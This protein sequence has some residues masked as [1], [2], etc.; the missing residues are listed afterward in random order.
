[1]TALP[2]ISVI[3]PAYNGKEHL[4]EAVESVLSQDYPN[5]ELLI[6][7]D[8]ST[9]GCCDS[10]PQSPILKLIRKSNGGVAEARNWGV[11]AS[12]GEFLAFLDQDDVWL[13]T[14]LSRQW[15]QL[16][17][18]EGEGI[19]LVFHK[20]FWKEGELP[21]K[22]AKTELL[23]S[24]HTS[25]VPGSW[26]FSRSLMEKVGPFDPV[27]RFGSDYDWL[28]RAKHQ[29]VPLLT[30]EEPLLLKRLHEGNESQYVK[31]VHK[32]LALLLHRSI[33]RHKQAPTSSV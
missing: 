14:K 24:P 18:T 27:Y 10:L 32:E 21:P 22:W 19:C 16:E 4:N 2:K 11:D 15:D 3:L 28:S 23:E 13:P 33:R 7:D 12:T 8:G 31:D 9:D 5:I 26:L 6:I 25:C 30:I 17:S 20:Y 1:M 29:N